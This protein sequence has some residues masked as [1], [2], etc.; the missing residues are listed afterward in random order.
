MRGWFVVGSLLAV[1]TSA[2]FVINCV[3]NGGSSPP[4]GE[5]AAG[6]VADE[7]SIATQITGASTGFCGACIQSTC[8]SAV[9]NCASD[10][11]CNDLSLQ[12]LSCLDGLGGNASVS[13]ETACVAPLASSSD[14]FAS[15]F[16]SCLLSCAGACADASV[17]AGGCASVDASISGLLATG[18]GACESCL[19]SSCRLEVNA[20]DRDCTCNA[21]AVTAVECLANLGS[22]PSVGAATSCIAPLVGAQLDSGL[23]ELG[24]CLYA[25]CSV[26]CGLTAPDAGQ[27]TEAGTDA[28][29]DAST[30]ASDAASSDDAGFDAGSEDAAF[31]ASVFDAGD[32]ICGGNNQA[33]CAGDTCNAGYH[34]VGTTCV[35]D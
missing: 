26:A 24:S 21:E 20:C 27:T 10:C 35:G 17:D 28:G 3:S 2:G 23:G 11:S 31:E 25:S 1:S 18:S 33:C 8:A 5:D 15:Y 30:D 34:C 19:Q 9:A 6:C 14:G 13:T 16:G 4:G 32:I 12:A 22:N 29:L 7:A